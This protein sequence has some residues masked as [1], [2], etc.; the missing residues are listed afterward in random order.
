MSS[1]S[2]HCTSQFDSAH[3]HISLLVH[4]SNVFFSSLEG[5]FRYLVKT[6]NSSTRRYKKIPDDGWH[7]FDGT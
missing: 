6:G 7:N 5:Y 4:I 3:P 2:V 1:K